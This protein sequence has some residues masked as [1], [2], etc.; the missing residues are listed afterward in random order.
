MIVVTP[1]P[2]DRS[3]SVPFGCWTLFR[4]V[5]VTPR[6]HGGRVTGRERVGE[7]LI[8]FAFVLADA[9]SL[10]VLLDSACFVREYQRDVS[11]AFSILV[12]ATKCR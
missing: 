4:R 10:G 7:N 9:L 2:P 12:R 5:D 6:V 8:D 3:A 1:I 11:H